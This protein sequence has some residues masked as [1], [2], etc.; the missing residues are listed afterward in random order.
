MDETLTHDAPASETKNAETIAI[1]SQ[2]TRR[3]LWL[4]LG[5][6]VFR[7][8]Y[9]A[10]D[11]FDLVHDE[12]YY[13]D[14]S[15]QLDYGYFSKPPMIA[16]IIGLSTRLLGNHEFAVRL[17]AVLLG[18]GSL[19]FVFLLGRRMYDARVGFWAALLAAMTPGN[20]AMSLLMTIDSPFLFFWSVALYAFWRMLERGEDRWKWLVVTMLIIGLGLL[21]KQTMLAMLVFGGLFV[22]LSKTDRFEALRPGLYVCAL[23]ALLFLVPVFVWN[24]QHDWVT[25]QHTSEHFQAKHVSLWQRTVGSLE[26]VGGLFGVISPVTFFLVAAVG[27]FGLLAFRRLGR[28]DQYLLCLSALPMLL[29]LGLSFKQRLELNW[30]APF[31]TA[32]MV[33]VAAWGLGHFQLPALRLSPSVGRLRHA[34]IVGAVFL[35]G[36]YALP[37]ALTLLGM[38]G[39]KLDVL[40][41]LRGWEE[42]GQ[43]VDQTLVEKQAPASVMIVT[44]GRAIAAELAFYMPRHPRVHVWDDNT[45]P[46]SQ[47]D[48]W[49]GPQGV[50]GDDVLVVTKGSEPVPDALRLAFA[51]VEKVDQVTIDIGQ[52][53]QHKVTIYRG[54]NFRGWSVAKA[55][56]AS[57][58]ERTLRR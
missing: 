55:F 7:L 23:G 14:W 18:T 3:A 38:N 28:R 2:W 46:L 35:A 53:R 20:V 8:C 27:M 40:A 19:W 41:R 24:Y 11:P 6:G 10:F 15:R 13:W 52:G 16:W 39:S 26:F 31:F 58:R 37:V 42:L 32:A 50:E 44:A 49:G 12:A 1:E 5:L 54:E 25:L 29:V 51:R 36:T 34:A 43:Q 45:Y 21:T 57:E 22:L 30:P 33:L 4:I 48:V 9:L 47:Y 56:Q 17:P